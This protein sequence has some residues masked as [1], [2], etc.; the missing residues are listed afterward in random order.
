MVPEPVTL[1]YQGLSAEEKAILTEIG[2]K[3]SGKMEQVSPSIIIIPFH[4]RRE[5]VV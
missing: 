1:F 2:L 4:S 5:S 3:H